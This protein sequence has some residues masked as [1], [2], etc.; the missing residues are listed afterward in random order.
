M[1]FLISGSSGAGKT[2]IGPHVARLVEGLVFHDADEHLGEP[3]EFWVDHGLEY[4]KEGV[5]MLLS[6]SRPY[7]ELLACPKTIDLSA[8]AGCLM[9]CD[10]LTRATR[11]R[12]RPPPRNQILGMDILCWASWHRMHADDPGWSQH[13]ITENGEERCWERWINWRRGDP[14]WNIP[15]FDTSD[16][17]LEETAAAIAAWVVGARRNPVVAREDR[18]WSR[19]EF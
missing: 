6:T 15:V 3:L 18:W 12:S 1:F 17:E 4:D 2:A 9:D 14:R 8:V 7:G 11:L 10:D 16:A 13:T 5:D 19:E